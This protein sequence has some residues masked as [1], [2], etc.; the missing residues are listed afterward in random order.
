MLDTGCWM[1]D[2][3]CSMLDTGYW[4]LDARCWIEELMDCLGDGFIFQAAAGDSRS[5]DATLKCNPAEFGTPSSIGTN[6]I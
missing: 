5:S 4:M 1:L 3:G 2:T 6:P